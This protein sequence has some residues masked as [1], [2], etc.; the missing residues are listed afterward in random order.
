MNILFI[1]LYLLNVFF[2]HKKPRKCAKYHGDKHLNKMI[3]E[4]TQIVSSVWH[5]LWFVTVIGN[6]D[7]D[8]V[9]R[10]I[11]KKSHEKHPMVLWASRSLAHYNYV[12]D[13][14]LALQ[15]EKKTRIENMQ[16][17]PAKDRKKW[18]PDHK[19]IPVLQFCKDNPPP[20]NLF[21]ENDTWSDPPK[22]MPEY[23]HNDEHGEPF[24]VIE[25]YR[26]FYSG[27][28]VAIAKLKWEPYAKTPGFVTRCQ[29]Y[30]QTRPDILLGIENDK[31]KKEK[32]LER[33]RVNRE[34]KRESKREKKEPKEEKRSN[35]NKPK[36]EKKR[37]RE[38]QIVHQIDEVEMNEWIDKQME[39][40]QQKKIKITL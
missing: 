12:C 8:N 11:Y 6:C 3:T 34:K 35:R 13:V 32:E 38:G 7:F 29:A 10:T 9:K 24:S 27:N 33:G 19:S 22:C 23:L 14:G 26:I 37:E 28:K 31:K 15:E 39:K 1:F 18:K 20:L 17:L 5:I 40:I 25:S 21:V 30:I 16:N 36:K 4:Y 2:L